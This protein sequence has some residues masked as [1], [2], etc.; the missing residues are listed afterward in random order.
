MTMRALRRSLSSTGDT[1]P[2]DVIELQSYFRGSEGPVNAYPGRGLEVP[3]YLLGSSDFS[4]QLAAELGLPFAFASHFAPDYLQV[5][6]NL[7][8]RGFRPSA[9]LEKPH[10]IVG[11][12]I[13]AAETD[14]EAER[15]FTSAQLMGLSLIR[16]RPGLLPPP[17]ESMNGRWSAAEQAAMQH[18]TAYA[19][20]GSPTTVRGRLREILDETAADELIAVSQIYNHHARLRSYEVAAEISR[21]L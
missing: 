4:A 21:E 19:V 14:A 8:R 18:R 12:G 2:Q 16:G 15:I 13:Y 3:L 5:A 1:F 10:V 6:I 11:V 20:V 9:S 7:Y 17:I